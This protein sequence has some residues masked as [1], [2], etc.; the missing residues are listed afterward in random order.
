MGDFP[1][2]KSLRNEEMDCL[3]IGVFNKEDKPIFLASKFKDFSSVYWDVNP[4]NDKN[5]YFSRLVEFYKELQKGNF[6]D[7]G[8]KGLPLG[9][10]I[11]GPINSSIPYQWS[12]H[13]KSLSLIFLEE[14][15]DMILE[16]SQ[17]KNFSFLRVDMPYA[18][19]T[20]EN[21]L[22][23]MNFPWDS[24]NGRLCVISHNNLSDILAKYISETAKYSIESEK[25]KP[26]LHQVLGDI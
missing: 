1:N 3:D 21:N 25:L 26:T 13:D 12:K 24:A 20:M 11:K 14:D 18:A 16:D 19:L 7:K 4:K 5:H 23:K 9:I 2:I 15:V 6:Q 8:N 10:I 22:T 17:F